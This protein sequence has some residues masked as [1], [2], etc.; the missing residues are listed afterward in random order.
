MTYKNHIFTIHNMK[1]GNT[2]QVEGKSA[3]IEWLN[4]YATNT[5]FK[6]FTTYNKFREWEK[7][8]VTLEN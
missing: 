8:N 4:K 5:N 6:Y 7:T 2:F 1:S 3:F